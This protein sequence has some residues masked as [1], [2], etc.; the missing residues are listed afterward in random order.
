[1]QL[2]EFRVKGKKRRR[3]ARGG[4][5]GT[6]SG[7]GQK[8]QK[9]RAGRRMRPAFRDLL[10][11][12]PKRRG[13][14]NR[15]KSQ[16]PVIMNVGDLAEFAGVLDRKKLVAIGIIPSRSTRSIKLLAGGEIRH[17]ITVRGIEVSNSAKMKIEKAGGTV[18]G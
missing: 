7:R 2:H 11:R 6:Y 9:S 5:R 15:P 12:L 3:V 8:G 17:A 13:F 16:K 14:K 18:E 4:K 10:I 1:M